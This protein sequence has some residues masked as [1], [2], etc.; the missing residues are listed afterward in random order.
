[1]CSL[2]L[3]FALAVYLQFIEWIDVFPWN[4]VRNGNGQEQLD[5][6][7]AVACALA[8]V[9]TYRGWKPG[10]WFGAALYF[11][12]LA[13]Q[14]STF[15]VPYVAGASSRWQRTWEAHFGHTVQWFPRVGNHLPPDA[16]HFILQVLLVGAFCAVCA[17]LW[18]LRGGRSTVHV[19]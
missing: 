3:Q 11:V 7:L 10:I 2:M 6:G 8:L 19:Q 13:L 18:A 15:W 1:M 14:I 4:D 9:S 12:W 5:M 17:H 16:S